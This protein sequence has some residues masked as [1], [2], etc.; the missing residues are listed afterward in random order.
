MFKL[1]IDELVAREAIR[2][3]LSSYVICGDGGDKDGFLRCFTEDGILEMDALLCEGRAALRKWL[4]SSRPYGDNV[5][6]PRAKIVRHHLTTSRIRF[7]S[8]EL[9]EGRTYFQ[10]LTDIG[11][12]HFGYYV[13]QF[14]NVDG[15]WLIAHRRVRLQWRAPDSF[16]RL[17]GENPS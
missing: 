3:T 15:E 5:V 11:L 4:D 17:N 7:E 12:D 16:I 9:A 6:R 2:L 10:T 13:D 8:A 1:P 14:R